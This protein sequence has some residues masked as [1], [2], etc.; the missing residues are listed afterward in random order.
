MF[1]S[2]VFGRDAPFRIILDLGLSGRTNG[3]VR[4]EHI[5]FGLNPG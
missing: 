1:A 5:G 3:S 2:P 4:S